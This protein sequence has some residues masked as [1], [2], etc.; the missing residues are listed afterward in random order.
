MV[1]FNPDINNR[2][3][4]DLITNNSKMCNINYKSNIHLNTIIKYSSKTNKYE[5][6]FNYNSNNVSRT[7]NIINYKYLIFTEIIQLTVSENI[8]MLL[9]KNND[10]RIQDIFRFNHPLIQTILILNN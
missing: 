1:S 10:F 5:I 7:M 3:I 9:N 8:C 4:H 2:I 6:I